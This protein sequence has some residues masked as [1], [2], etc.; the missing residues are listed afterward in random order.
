MEFS[1]L[2]IGSL[3]ILRST[4]ADFINCGKIM[5][6]LRL[7]LIECSVLQLTQKKRVYRASPWQRS[8]CRIGGK[9][10]VLRCQLLWR[11]SKSQVWESRAEF[12]CH[13]HRHRSHTGPHSV[14]APSSC[15]EAGGGAP[16]KGAYWGCCK[17]RS[18][19]ARSARRL[20]V[21]E[22][23]LTNGGE[24]VCAH[25]SSKSILDAML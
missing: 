12:W 19:R 6:Y 3:L 18:A 9:C 24:E 25:N 23:F 13:P 22:T 20:M 4:K 5:E 2:I 14:L 1:L 7:K 15:L 10:A 16:R 8:C 17:Q 21:S 11:A